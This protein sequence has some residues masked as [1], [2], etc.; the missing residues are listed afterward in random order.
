MLND[1][2][3][4]YFSIDKQHIK[5][6]TIETNKYAGD[7]EIEIWRYNPALLAENSFVDK[8]SLFLLLKN[9]DNER[10]E[11][12]LEILINEMQWLEE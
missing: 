1:E 5:N 10:I 3:K 11:I 9:I 12:E 7:N 2:Q 8:L 6:L 4:L